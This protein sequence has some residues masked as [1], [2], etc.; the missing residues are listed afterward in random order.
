MRKETKII[1]I[2]VSY[3][4]IFSFIEKTYDIDLNEFTLQGID[5]NYYDCSDY[6]TDE[7][8]LQKR[9]VTEE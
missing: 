4:E 2:T 1:D 9:E 5:G 6:R 3:E 8:N 7:M